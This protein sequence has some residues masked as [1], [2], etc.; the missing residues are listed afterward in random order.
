[1]C[2]IIIMYLLYC[3]ILYWIYYTLSFL[4]YEMKDAPKI[5]LN[6]TEMMQKLNSETFS[7]YES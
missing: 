1:M 3:S 7:L 2:D 4:L 5:F 6:A